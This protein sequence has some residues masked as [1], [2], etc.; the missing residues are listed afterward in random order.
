MTA[1]Q[2]RVLVTVEGRVVKESPHRALLAVE[3]EDG[4]SLY[5][6]TNAKG[7]TV[8][9]LPPEYEWTDGDVIVHRGNVWVRDAGV[10]NNS[11]GRSGGLSDG[12]AGRTLS[13]HADATVLRYQ[14]GGD[15]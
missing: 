15:Q 7:V 10:W 3:T 12:A 4:A 11:T 6:P 5:V 13:R 8:E 14:A 9:D 1:T 2:R